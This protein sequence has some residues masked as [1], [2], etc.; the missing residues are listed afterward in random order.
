VLARQRQAYIL[1]RVREDGGVRVSDLVRELSVSDM[2]IR[3]DLELLA[4]QGLIEKVH[5]GATALPGSAQFEPTFAAKSSLQQLEKEA[6]AAAAV[7]FV[8][9]GSALGISAGTTTYAI[10]RRLVEIPGLTVVTNSPRAA[11]VLHEAGR[12]DQTIILTGGVRTPSDALV[13]PFAVSALRSVHLDLVLL[14][15]HGMD[16][17]SGFTS[18]NLLEAETD[19]T[20][21]DAG[22]RL[23]VVADHTKWGV[24]GL[25][26]I[27]RL[28]QADVL[29]TDGHLDGA[30]REVLTGQVRELLEARPPDLDPSTRPPAFDPSPVRRDS[31]SAVPVPSAGLAGRG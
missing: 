11:D 27:A 30:A 25:S 29:I 8:E 12:S 10:A 3:R 18:P 16:E 21:V 20:L 9:P 6:I 22:R 17:R 5:G 26:S 19:R 2:T 14:G 24:V 15:V 31:R 23:I 7:G 28:D 13:G 1:D 4:D